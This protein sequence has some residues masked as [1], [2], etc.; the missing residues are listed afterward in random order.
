MDE[1][2]LRRFLVE[3]LQFEPAFR[4]LLVGYFGFESEFVDWIGMAI[5]EDLMCTLQEQEGKV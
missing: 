3:R 1:L 2:N 5:A 4:F